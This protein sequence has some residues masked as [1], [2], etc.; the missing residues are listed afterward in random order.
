MPYGVD[1]RNRIRFEFDVLCFY[2]R[3]LRDKGIKDLA[4]ILSLR[5]NVFDKLS[6]C[7]KK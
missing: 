5:R 6:F 2:M 1:E 3:S 4:F 7:S